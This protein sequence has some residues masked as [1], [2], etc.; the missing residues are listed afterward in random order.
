MRK[1]AECSQTGQEASSARH[2]NKKSNRSAMPAP[3]STARYRISDPPWLMSALSM[4]DLRDALL[5]PE[6]RHQIKAISAVPFRMSGEKVSGCS[7]HAPPLRWM[8]RFGNVGCVLRSAGFDFHEDD[9][10][11]TKSDRI[12]FAGGALE[13]AAKN[14]I[15]APTQRSPGLPLTAPSEGV[16]PLRPPRPSQ[17]PKL[18]SDGREVHAAF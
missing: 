15:P 1:Y 12:H 16:N 18:S 6:N 3:S 5:R 2:V 10:M 8:N 14:A 17:A 13:V 7:F 4:F 9:K 11:I